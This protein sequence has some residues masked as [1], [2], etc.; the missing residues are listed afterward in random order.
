MPSRLPPRTQL[1]LQLDPR[2]PAT[3]VLVPEE[4]V[5]AL[6]DLLLAALGRDLRV[7]AGGGDEQQDH[8]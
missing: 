7:P 6:A 4:A 1:S 5:P 8:G 2:P 3:P